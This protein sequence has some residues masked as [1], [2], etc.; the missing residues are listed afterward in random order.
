MRPATLRLAAWTALTA[1]LFFLAAADLGLRSRSAL[2]EARQQELWRDNP[3]LKKRYYDAGLED[4]LLALKKRA[5][6]GELAREEAARQEALLRAERD[7]YVSESSARLAYTWYKTAAEDFPSPLNPWAAE[8]AK[9]L[10]SARKAW[11]AELGPAA[12]ARIAD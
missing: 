6:S 9:S 4:K 8:A 12:S 1:V 11:Q 2:L 10:P 3:S 5:G 7:L